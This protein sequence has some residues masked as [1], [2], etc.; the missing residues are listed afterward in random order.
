[1]RGRSRGGAAS[2]ASRVC[3]SIIRGPDRLALAGC[4]WDPFGAPSTTFSG[5]RASEVCRG[6]AA[7][8]S[9]SAEALSRLV[10]VGPRGRADGP[11]YD[12]GYSDPEEP[13]SVRLGIGEED[14]R[15]GPPHLAEGLLHE[16]MHLQ[17]DLWEACVPLVRRG[18]YVFAVV[19]D[20]MQRAAA[21]SPSP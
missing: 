7:S 13:L 9:P 20:C 11:D 12:V 16:A 3:S 1:M 4:P 21:R 2:E 14:C 15:N 6:S 10:D 8:D 17:P 19:A 18:V 5:W